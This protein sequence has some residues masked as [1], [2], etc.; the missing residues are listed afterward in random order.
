MSQTYWHVIQE[1]IVMLAMANDDSKFII[2][3]EL[4]DVKESRS[5]K[6]NIITTSKSEHFQKQWYEYTFA[7]IDFVINFNILLKL[8]HLGVE[9]NSWQ[10]SIQSF[11]YFQI[12]H[13]K[14][15]FAQIKF[16][17]CICVLKLI[18]GRWAELSLK[19]SLNQ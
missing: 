6:W 10:C 17:P 1:R 12:S 8:F 18:G 2:R 19:Y 9:E 7:Q 16:V 5:V 15:Q 14:C 4:S 13:W 3:L 11:K